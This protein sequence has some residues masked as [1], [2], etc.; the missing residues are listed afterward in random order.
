MRL[1][2]VMGTM[3]PTP[4]AAAVERTTPLEIQLTHSDLKQWA[5]AINSAQSNLIANGAEGGFATLNISGTSEMGFDCKFLSPVIDR[6][7]TTT[8]Y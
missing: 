2:D 6:F 3:A 5:L 1:D 8:F 7:S 4:K